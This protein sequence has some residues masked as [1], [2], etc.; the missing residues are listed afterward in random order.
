MLSRGSHGLTINAKT[1]QL[2]ALCVHSPKT[3]SFFIRL[4]LNLRVSQWSE[5]PS[6]ASKLMRLDEIAEKN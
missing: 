4:K 2:K 6:T 3:I 1:L 5:A